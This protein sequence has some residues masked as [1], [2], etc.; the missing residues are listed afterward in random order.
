[1]YDEIVASY[2]LQLQLMAFCLHLPSSLPHVP[3]DDE[4]VFPRFFEGSGK[5]ENG[6][7]NRLN[8][9]QIAHQAGQAVAALDDENIS[10]LQQLILI[11]LLAHTNAIFLI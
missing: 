2:R 10:S 6:V 1:V 5:R 11:T 9:G 3:P 4:R 7:T 8:V